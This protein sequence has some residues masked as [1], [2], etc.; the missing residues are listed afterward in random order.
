MQDLIIYDFVSGL[1][2]CYLF[3]SKFNSDRNWYT[4]LERGFEELV[5][6]R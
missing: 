3:E 4:S 5:G 1:L 2:S 6:I